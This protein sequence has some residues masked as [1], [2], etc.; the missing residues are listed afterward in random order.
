MGR[1]APGL[2]VPVV[3]AS[4][5]LAP[6]DLRAETAG[7]APQPAAPA[8]AAGVCGASED[9]VAAVREV[10]ERGEILLD[11]GRL[12]RLSDLDFAI[13]ALSPEVWRANLTAIRQ[14]L[15][16]AHF[17]VSALAGTPDRWGRTPV[18]LVPVPEPGDERPVRSV[19]E[20]LLESGLARLWPFEAAAACRHD[21]RPS[22]ERAQRALRGVWGENGAK[23]L[24]A[25]QPE[26]IRARAGRFAIVE[27]R[28]ISVGSRPQ[29]T[30]LNFGRVYR[31][32]FSATIPKRSLTAFISAGMSPSSLAHKRI[33]I[34]GI[35]GGRQAP[36][37]EITSP[38]QIERIEN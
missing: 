11:D 20:D 13:D 33:R 3:L 19:H 10:N 26:A 22:E 9:I 5:L 7:L 34:R 17:Y 31:R 38:D 29:R 25:T 6:K 35:V 32:D 15:V 24:A 36:T 16:G 37:I 14:K 18:V 1:L 30:Y 12:A 28:V 27:G 4:G 21:L 2:L 8:P 23:A